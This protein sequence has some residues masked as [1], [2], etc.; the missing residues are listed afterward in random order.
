MLLKLKRTPGIYL[1]GFMG[2]GKSTI[3]RLLA[4]ELGWSFTDLDADIEGSQ[5][6]S[7]A[8][9][10]DTRGEAEFRKIEA[11]AVRKRVYEVQHGKPMVIALGGGAF[12]Q[13]ANQA[14]LIEH[15]V[16]V[17]IDCPLA[18][19]RTRLE[20]N[21]DRPLARDPAKFEKLYADRRESYSK[22]DYRIEADSDDP[23]VIVAAI[24]KLPI[25]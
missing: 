18:R 21:S 11:E 17:W 8:D 4:D 23:A 10:F 7:I 14:L 15:G 22:A 16:P 19:L 2:S 20:G 1:V 13:E 12:T 5:G 24:L 3:G 9:I 25:F 6:A